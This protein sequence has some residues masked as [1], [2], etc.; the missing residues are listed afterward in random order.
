MSDRARRTV[1]HF[2]TQLPSGVFN[3][4][5]LDRR[6][7]AGIDF[8]VDHLHQRFGYTAPTRDI[9]SGLDGVEAGYWV[10]MCP[11]IV[12]ETMEPLADQKLEE[13]YLTAVSLHLRG[14]V[15][16]RD[17][18]PDQIEARIDDELWAL[19][20][21]MLMVMSDVMMRYHDRLACQG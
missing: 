4:A 20:P 11:E 3:L 15:D 6:Q 16:H 18:S 7:W 17:G 8:P 21:A 9:A 10:F 1:E 14:H 13:L 5:F 12:A 2:T 19:D